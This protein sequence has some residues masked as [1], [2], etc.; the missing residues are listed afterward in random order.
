MAVT[1]SPADAL[2]MGGA[3]DVLEE[4]FIGEEMDGGSIV[5]EDSIGVNAAKGLKLDWHSV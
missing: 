4:R 3:E 1:P 5:Q 2:A